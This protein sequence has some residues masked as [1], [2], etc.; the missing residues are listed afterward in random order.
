MRQEASIEIW[1]TWVAM[2]SNI[3]LVVTTQRIHEISVCMFILLF[4]CVSIVFQNMATYNSH[5]TFRHISETHVNIYTFINICI[6]S[7]D[8]GKM[9]VKI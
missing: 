1:C 7:L 2:G 8:L 6:I 3:F 5:N 9:M 4:F